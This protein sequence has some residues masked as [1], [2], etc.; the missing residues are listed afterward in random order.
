[1]NCIFA[2]NNAS[3]IRPKP[4]DRIVQIGSIFLVVICARQNNHLPKFL[5]VHLELTQDLLQIVHQDIVFQ[6]TEMAHHPATPVSKHIHI[7]G[8]ARIHLPRVHKMRAQFVRLALRVNPM[9]ATVIQ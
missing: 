8:Q 9:D 7:F 3:F 2:Q 6:Q 5:D 4:F 1:L